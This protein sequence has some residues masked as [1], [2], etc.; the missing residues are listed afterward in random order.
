MTVIFAIEPGDP[1]LPPNV[2]GSLERPRHWIRCLCAAGTTINIFCDF[3]DYVCWDI[4][5]N[6]IPGTNAH[7]IFIWDNLAAHHSMYVHSTVT[8]RD[9]PSLF[10]IVA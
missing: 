9:G 8:N 10:S 4:E 3:C 5:T 6:N 7:W 2:R 1:A